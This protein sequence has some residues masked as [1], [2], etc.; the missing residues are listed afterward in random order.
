MTLYCHNQEQGERDKK[1]HIDQHK[2]QIY[3]MYCIRV[4]ESCVRVQV[5]ACSMCDTWNWYFDAFVSLCSVLSCCSKCPTRQVHTSVCQ[6]HPQFCPVTHP[7]GSD[8]SRA[9]TTQQTKWRCDDV[10]MTSN[11]GYNDI[12]KWHCNKSFCRVPLTL[13]QRCKL[14]CEMTFPE[15]KCNLQWPCYTVLVF[16]YENVNDIKHS[17]WINLFYWNYT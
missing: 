8:T 6:W 4:S 16:S 11:I 1:F 9:L 10:A 3:Q 5:D 12:V 13:P 2:I 7:L 15:P 14:C 17:I